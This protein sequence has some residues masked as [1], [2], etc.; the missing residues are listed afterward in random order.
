[1]SPLSL[2]VD[3]TP[4]IGGSPPGG[5]NCQDFNNLTQQYNE[6]GLSHPFLEMVYQRTSHMNPQILK[7]GKWDGRQALQRRANRSHTSGWPSI[8]GLVPFGV[9]KTLA[10]G[11]DG[12]RTN[13]TWKQDPT[14]R[15]SVV[16]QVRQTSNVSNY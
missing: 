2:I 12:D 10:L 14:F 15:C 4:I 3:A 6:D 9:L 13:E 7:R 5:L 11:K 16:V 1:M 8:E